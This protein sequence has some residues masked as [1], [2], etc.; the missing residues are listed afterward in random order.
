[1]AS[2]L[3]S[4]VIRA[5]TSRQT[6]RGSALHD[7]GGH[8]DPRP[9]AARS[10]RRSVGHPVGR[11]GDG[12]SQAACRLPC[13]PVKPV[14]IVSNTSNKSLSQLLEQGD[15]QAVIGADLPSSFKEP[16]SSVCLDFARRRRI[17]AGPRSFRSAPGVCGGTFTS[18]I[19]HCDQPVQRVQQSKA[20]AHERMRY[21]G[22]RYML[23]WLPAELDEIERSAAIPGPMASSRTGRR[24]KLWCSSWSISR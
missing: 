24:W 11:R 17:T 22:A 6:G 12:I 7:D 16:T 20:L 5:R 21:L 19:L 13:C 8:L 14:T 23:P 18:G 3:D 2:S 9:A 1:M 10:R 4:R 15:V